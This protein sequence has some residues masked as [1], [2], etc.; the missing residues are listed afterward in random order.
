MTRTEKLQTVLK[1]GD[2]YLVVARTNLLDEIPL[3]LCQTLEMA[4][5]EAHEA[6]QDAIY[7]IAHEVMGVDA[8]GLCAIAIVVFLGGKPIDLEITRPWT[9]QDDI[10]ERPHKASGL[11]KPVVKRGKKHTK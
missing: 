10:F 4:R 11:R 8:A 3:A 6:T 7:K 2:A 9:D 1:F 5:T